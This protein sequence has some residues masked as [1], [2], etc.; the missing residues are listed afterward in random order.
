M[1][2][3]MDIRTFFQPI[4]IVSLNTPHIIFLHFNAPHPPEQIN[5]IDI[6]IFLTADEKNGKRNPKIVEWKHMLNT[7]EVLTCATLLI[8]QTQM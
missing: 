5:F 7:L 2:T 6:S 3:D 8:L 1:D 4:P